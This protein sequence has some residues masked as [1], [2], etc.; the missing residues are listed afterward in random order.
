MSL[1]T[2]GRPGKPGRRLFDQ[3]VFTECWEGYAPGTT[4]PS[5]PGWSAV[6]NGGSVQQFNGR[7]RWRMLT[8][9]GALNWCMCRVDALDGLQN[10]TI[11]AEYETGLGGNLGLL[12]ARLAGSGTVTNYQ[13]L[14]FYIDIVSASGQY[15]YRLA[16]TS[17]NAPTA[18]PDIFLV[19]FYNRPTSEGLI[20]PNGVLT[21]RQAGNAFTFTVQIP[22]LSI[23][24]SH[25]QIIS[26]Y[27]ANGRAGVGCVSQSS[28]QR[29]IGC[30]E[31]E[32]LA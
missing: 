11:R 15:R 13:G 12:F 27:S 3:S 16:C 22:D 19:E 23:V 30:V 10:F 28:Q 24:A 21:L 32:T 4:A 9:S 2:L 18:A 5:I 14:K 7:N 25:T 8:G 1:F 29:I 17:G 31:A 6:V 26:T 20:L